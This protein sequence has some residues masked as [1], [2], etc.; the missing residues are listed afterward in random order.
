M[1]KI[2]Y[3]LYC[4]TTGIVYNATAEIKTALGECRP[5]SRAI[6]DRYISNIS[7]DLSCDSI[8]SKIYWVLSQ[9]MIHPATKVHDT[10]VW[11]VLYDPA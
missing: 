2:L 7:R 6:V 8:H 11:L 1:C 9:A 3:D 4:L 5:Q 10:L